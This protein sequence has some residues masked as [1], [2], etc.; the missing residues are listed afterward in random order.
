MCEMQGLEYD[1][2]QAAV[3]GTVTLTLPRWLELLLNDANYHQPQHLSI[4]IPSYRCVGLKAVVG[5]GGLGPRRCTGMGV[6]LL[7]ATL[8]RCL[9]PLLARR[10]H[11]L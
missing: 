2:A 8:R 3:N 4:S 1:S 9:W 10:L 6:T 7:H 11:A 5:I